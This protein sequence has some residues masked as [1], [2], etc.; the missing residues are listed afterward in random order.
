MFYTCTPKFDGNLIEF[1]TRSCE[2]Q[3]SNSNHGG[4]CLIMPLAFTMCFG[5]DM[6]HA[7]L[8]YMVRSVVENNHCSRHFNLWSDLNSIV[9]Q[10][11][12]IR[13]L[14]KLQNL[15]KSITTSINKMSWWKW[16][17]HFFKIYVR[18]QPFSII[19]VS[20]FLSVGNR[21]IPKVSRRVTK[22]WV[23]SFFDRNVY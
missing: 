21:V 20:S 1:E 11:K 12:V 16:R 15:L 14:C 18:I 9:L 2:S 17:V 8:L 13:F 7:N 19:Q 3:V 6:F 5:I 22:L 23:S 4:N 10:A